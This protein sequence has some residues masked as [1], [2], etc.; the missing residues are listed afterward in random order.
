MTYDIE[1]GEV[2]ITATEFKAKCLDLLDRVM[3]GD[4]NKVHITKRGREF[5]VLT[6]PSPPSADA[7]D[8]Y[9]MFGSMRGSVKPT[10]GLDILAP[11]HDPELDG[12]VHAEQGVWEPE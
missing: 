8:A 11:I 12:P 3:S 6:G 5:G 10:G 4:L 1:N 7:W 2:V 9:D